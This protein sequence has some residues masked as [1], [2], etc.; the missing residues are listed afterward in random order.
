MKFIKHKDN[1]EICFE[2]FAS[3]DQ[4]LFCYEWDMNGGDV[5]TSPIIIP[6]YNVYYGDGWQVCE[7]H[8]DV[9]K[10]DIT[11]A[12]AKWTSLKK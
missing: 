8:K 3:D 11:F 9:F 7:N 4:D 1:D 5:S 2:I 6:K 10:N 12:E